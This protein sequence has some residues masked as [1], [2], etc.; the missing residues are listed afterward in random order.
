MLP[1]ATD[2]HD[3]EEKSDRI[4]D[5]REEEMFLRSKELHAWEND[6]YIRRLRVAQLF[7]CWYEPH[8]HLRHIVHVD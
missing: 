6:D 7:I 5:E 2:S 1:E 8:V 4:D 3:D